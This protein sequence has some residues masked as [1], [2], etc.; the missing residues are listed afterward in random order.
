VFFA[1]P[2][3]FSFHV[4]LFIQVKVVFLSFEKKI[5]SA[6]EERAEKVIKSAREH[7]YLQPFKDIMTAFFEKGGLTY[8]EKLLENNE[9]TGA[10]RL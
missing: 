3:N 6:A 1:L 10:K 4:S 2:E 8:S 9:R 5:L 7:M